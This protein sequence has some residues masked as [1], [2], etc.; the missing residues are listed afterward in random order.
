[1]RNIAVVVTTVLGSLSALLSSACSDAGADAT[2]NITHDV[3][4]PLTLVPTGASA[5]QR[6]GIEAALALWRARGMSTLVV[7]EPVAGA[8]AL[9]VRFEVAAAAFHGVY[10]DEAGVVYVNAALTSPSALAIVIAHELGH[11]FGLPHVTERA[12][13]MNPGNLVLPPTLEDEAALVALW[14]A[15]PP[16]PSAPGL[17]PAPADAETH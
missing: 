14:G 15:C 9:E 4:A 6:D 16:A 7:D 2:I 11:A 8:P 13:L 10:D 12:S 1:M 3:C 5:V 17:I